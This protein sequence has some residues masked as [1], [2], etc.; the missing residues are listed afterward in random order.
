MSRY[1]FTHSFAPFLAIVFMAGAVLRCGWL[2]ATQSENLMLVL[3]TERKATSARYFVT[4]IWGSTRT[5]AVKG[6]LLGFE[7]REARNMSRLA[8]SQ[9]SKCKI[10]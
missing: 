4:G 5:L 8:A 9:Y 7:P 6:A 10:R 2:G 3:R 1:L